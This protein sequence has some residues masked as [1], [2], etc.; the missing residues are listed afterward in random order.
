MKQAQLSAY[1]QN[2]A[3]LGRTTQ[4]LAE[5]GL[6]AFL[7]HLRAEECVRGG[8]IVPVDRGEVIAHD[9]HGV[10]AERER[11]LIEAGELRVTEAGRRIGGHCECR[12]PPLGRRQ[13]LLGA[14]LPR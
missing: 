12:G 11:A 5:A 1:I 2:F 3:Q 6:R 7:L 4:L 14:T 10:P 8:V 9:L 13:L